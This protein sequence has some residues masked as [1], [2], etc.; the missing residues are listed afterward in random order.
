VSEELSENDQKKSNIIKAR[1]KVS[2][3]A[4]I[5]EAH[6][7]LQAEIRLNTEENTKKTSLKS[8]TP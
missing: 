7:D 8:K 5:K 1:R 4:A 3:E 6:C 2:K